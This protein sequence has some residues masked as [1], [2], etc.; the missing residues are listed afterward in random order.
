MRRLIPLIAALVGI[1]LVAGQA[2]AQQPKKFQIDAAARPAVERGVAYLKG[3][4]N[5]LKNAGEAG[6]VAMALNKSLVPPNDQAMVACLG[7]IGTCFSGEGY[8]PETRGGPDNYEAS[9]VLMALVNLDHIGYKPQI[10]AV[11]QWIIAHQMANGAWDYSERTQGDESM[12]Q[13][14]LLALYEAESAGIVIKPEVWDH[15][16]KYYLSV[17]AA[18]GSWTYHRDAPNQGETMSMTAAGVG[19]LLICQKSLAKYRRGQDRL[20]PYLTPVNPD[21]TPMD[22]NYK[23]ETSVKSITDGVTKG[24][25]WMTGHFAINKDPMLGQSPYYALYGIERIAGLDPTNTL[26][27]VRW[28]TRGLDF[29]NSSQEPTGAWNAQHEN[30][31]NTCW[32]LLFATKST[33]QM[34]EK[35]NIRRLG[36]GGQR[37]G[38]GLPADLNNVEVVRGQLVARPMGGAIEGMLKVLENPDN[39]SYESAIRGLVDKYQ[40]E[41]PKVLRP[42]KDRF[43]KMLNEKVPERRQ[44][45]VWGLGHIGDLDVA[46]A[47]IKALLD[48][49]PGVVNDA[50][51]GLQILSRKADGFG[52]SGE[53]PIEQRIEAARKWQAWFQSVKPPDLDAPDLALPAA[54]AGGAAPAVPAAAPAPADTAQAPSR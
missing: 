5:N 31:P 30:V 45:G 15:A 17:Q 20:N 14:C 2:R 40:A 39:D 18:G 23:V 52:P 43:R 7:R 54:P 16:A 6:I 50:R 25:S 38:S 9:V 11:A 24:L 28:Y 26:D 36:G 48:N 1:G 47:L 4:V 49:D 35:I 37:L 53:A 33:V 12:T 21:G 41:G 3:Q 44:L 22:S 34:N 10:D 42:L 29:V 27:G 13:Y 32:A 51:I 19:S 46:P 8:K